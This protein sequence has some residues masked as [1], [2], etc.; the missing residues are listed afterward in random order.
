MINSFI[1]NFLKF[2][3]NLNPFGLLIFYGLILIMVLIIVL[4]I[5]LKGSNKVSTKQLN[6]NNDNIELIGDDDSLNNIGVIAKKIE[7]EID[8]NVINLTGFEEEQEES[9]IISYDEL[10]NKIKPDA[11]ETIETITEEEET[12]KK[13]VTT[14]VISPIF[15][16]TEETAKKER[17]KEYIRQITDINEVKPEPIPNEPIK[18]INTLTSSNEVEKGE[19]FLRALK[20]LKSNLN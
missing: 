2:Y 11:S 20:D 3:T 10:V 12:P 18:Q 5:V 4:L 6:K 17:A 19:N 7:A 9:S 13:F 14:P 15:G 1:D 8:N 16:Y